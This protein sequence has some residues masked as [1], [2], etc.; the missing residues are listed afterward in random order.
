MV[1][2]GAFDKVSPG[3]LGWLN[4]TG[5]S[6]IGSVITDVLC[7]EGGHSGNGFRSALKR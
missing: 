2:N 1:Q 6:H 7:G 4:W 5:L 3:T